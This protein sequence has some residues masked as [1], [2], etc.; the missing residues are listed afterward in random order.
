MEL[1]PEQVEQDKTLCEK[2]KNEGHIPTLISLIGEAG[3]RLP[4]YIT[5]HE[6]DA[7]AL[8]KEREHLYHAAMGE[9]H[10]FR[11]WKFGRTMLSWACEDVRKLGHRLAVANKEIERLREALREVEDHDNFTEGWRDIARAALEPKP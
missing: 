11:E 4:D 9:D 1:T 2:I 5:Q 3:K 8:A 6:A 7:V 10:W